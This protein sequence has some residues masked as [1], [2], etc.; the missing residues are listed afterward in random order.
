MC[1]ELVYSYCRD[2][3]DVIYRDQVC[4]MDQVSD[5]DQVY[6]RNLENIQVCRDHSVRCRDHLEEN[7]PFLKKKSK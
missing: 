7:A 6:D 4:N 5:M 1:W 2:L 3:D